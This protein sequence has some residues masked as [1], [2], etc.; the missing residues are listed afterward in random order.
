MSVTH[1]DVTVTYK[2]KPATKIIPNNNGEN[3]SIDDSADKLFGI[4]KNRK[5]TNNVEQ[6]IR[7]MSKGRKF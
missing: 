1:F 2:G 6:H 7:N 4:W 3:I 5:D